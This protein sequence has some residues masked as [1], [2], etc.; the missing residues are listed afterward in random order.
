MEFNLNFMHP[1]YGTIFNADID[2]QF[3]VEEMIENLLLSGF[4]PPN[5]AGYDFALR[6]D[7]LDRQMT[8]A[9]IDALEDGDVI[10][11]I[12]H[13]E[14]EAPVEVA[15]KKIR[16]HLLHPTQ[17]LTEH[18]SVSLDANLSYILAR[19]LH[20]NFIQGDEANF[21]IRKGEQILDLQLSVKELALEHEDYLQ[22]VQ[23]DYISPQQSAQE[24]LQQQ[25][26]NLQ[27]TLQAEVK[28]IKD[29]LPSANLIPID[30]TR[31]VNPTID[32]YETF[33]TILNR[34]RS[35][36]GLPPIQKITII[37]T[38]LIVTGTILLLLI[39]LIILKIAGLF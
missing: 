22:I 2:S 3:T 6:N 11:V 5:K 37:P 33:D 8:F 13:K 18:K 26:E 36:N 30:P 25:V 21:E 12:M 38:K 32:F 39:I 9:E 29:N 27:E 15:P 14:N 17:N 16:L 10:R 19:L 1:Q 31:S 7:M 4:L 28:A 20:K 24:A 35:E 23:L 34:M